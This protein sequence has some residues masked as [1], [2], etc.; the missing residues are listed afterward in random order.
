MSIQVYFL[1]FGVG[2]FGVV[3]VIFLKHFLLSRIFFSSD[4]KE[5]NQYSNRKG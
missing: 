1:L 3:K 4:K 2:D 5:E